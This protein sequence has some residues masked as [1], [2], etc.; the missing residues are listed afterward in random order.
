MHEIPDDLGTAVI[1]QRMVFGNAG[2]VS[3][4]G[5]GFTRDPALG[6]RGLYMDF[7]LDAQ[8]E[9]VVG[10]RQTVQGSSSLAVVAP[11]VLGEIE[12]VCPRLEAEFGDAQEFEL[13]VQEGELFLLQTRTAKRTPWAALRIATD[14]VDEGLISRESGACAPS[15]PRSR[16]AQARPRRR[17]ERRRGALRT[18]PP[19][20]WASRAARSRSTATR[21]SGSRA[22]ARRRCW[23]VPTP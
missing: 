23:C 18:R 10:G 21:R 15:W 4:A 17:V 13:T 2:G 3:G 1:L 9:D 7:L 8:G 14:Q 16:G 11:D 19:R 22:R 5:V 20:A 6:E 12:Q